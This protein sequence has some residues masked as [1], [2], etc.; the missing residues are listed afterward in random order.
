MSLVRYRAKRNFSKTAEPRG[1]ARTPRRQAE[2]DKSQIVFVIQKHAATRL[3][4]D[5]RL[6]IDGVLKSWAVPKGIPLTKGTK[7]LAVQVEDHPR[8][9]GG[10]E[11]VIPEGNYG[12]G[13]VMLWD[14]GIC[15]VV[16]RNPAAALRQG[17]L[18]FRL[19][20]QKLRGQ[21]TLVRM[22]SRDEENGK[23][24]KAWLLIKTEDHAAPISARAEDRSVISGRTM[25]QIANQQD[26]LWQSN[27]DSPREHAGK[28]TGRFGR[29]ARGRAG[30]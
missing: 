12:A 7:N 18:I 13:T 9:Y 8:E 29:S 15:E 6:E 4:Y 21:W 2:R 30:R 27:H 25:K 28:K 26:R 3:H 20:G 23:D 16:E 22:R 5:F 24:G 11:G 19:N 14:A 1:S 10:F 17:K